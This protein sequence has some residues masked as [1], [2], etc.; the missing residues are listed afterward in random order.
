MSHVTNYT[1][2]DI[3]TMTGK[4]PFIQGFVTPTAGRGSVAARKI[5]LMHSG[6]LGS[7]IF[8]FF[9]VVVV[10]VGIGLLAIGGD[11]T[12]G[13]AIGVGGGTL[14]ISLAI[15]GVL[16]YKGFFKN[17]TKEE[18]FELIGED[19]EKAINE[20]NSLQDQYGE[21]CRKQA[22]ILRDQATQTQ[23][24]RAA[25]LEETAK[26]YDA[27]AAGVVIAKA[28]YK[29]TIDALVAEMRRI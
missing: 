10:A 28:S 9:G 15:S 2:F 4:G 18:V 8:A 26:E 1:L 6:A 29:A 25:D 24:G 22:Q 19:G 5:E 7:L 21:I 20:L 3:A 23:G 11:P 14:I 12:G 16:F 17:L 13:I 27:K